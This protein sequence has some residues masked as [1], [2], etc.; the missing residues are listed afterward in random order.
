MFF[1]Y[2]NAA[3]HRAGIAA[4]IPGTD[5]WNK[6]FFI[7]LFV[8]L[9]LLMAASVCETFIYSMPGMATAEKIFLYFEYLL[10]SIPMPIFT[11]YLLH[12]CAREKWQQSGIFR[13]VIVI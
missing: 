13:A 5:R 2:R 7:F 8:T 10:L 11:A 4:I 9:M 12:I 6:R 1:V 3:V